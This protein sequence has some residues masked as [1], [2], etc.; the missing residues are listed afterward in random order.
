M[1]TGTL[2]ALCWSLTILLLFPTVEISSFAPTTTTRTTTTTTTTPNHPR[3]EFSWRLYGKRQK[4]RFNSKQPCKNRGS[5]VQERLLQAAQ[6]K[7]NGNDTD[8]HVVLMVDANNVRGTEGFQLTTYDLIR[9]LASWRRSMISI[10]SKGKENSSLEQQPHEPGMPISIL[11][12]ID[13]GGRP[14]AVSLDGIMLVFAGPNRTAD[15]VMVQDCQWLAAAVEQQQRQQFASGKQLKQ[16]R[17]DLFVVTNDRE[18]RSRCLKANRPSITNQDATSGSRTTKEASSKIKAKMNNNGNAVVVQV[19]DSLP[20]SGSLKTHWREEAMV[21]PLTSVTTATEPIHNTDQ[22]AELGNAMSK[23]ESDLRSYQRPPLLF[24][25]R[26]ERRRQGRQ[27]LP[28]TTTTTTT[29]DPP[30]NDDCET[31][32]LPRPLGA[33]E[34]PEKTWQR[35]L[36]AERLRRILLP[37]AKTVESSVVVEA[38]DST[39]TT[40]ATTATTEEH[41]FFWSS[42]QAMHNSFVGPPVNLCYDQR[43]R[44]D[45]NAQHSLSRYLADEDNSKSTAGS[46]ELT[47]TDPID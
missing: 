23:V 47:A 10:L 2:L 26:R 20:F 42:Y 46:N 11:C 37:S 36:V 13:H 5:S 4:A 15:D 35:V 24:L 9:V 38:A 33:D 29:A 6:V 21:T 27:L 3:C 17:L 7:V 44:H 45:K 16:Q 30:S 40:T 31:V 39:T 8:H 18:L 22:E 12:M 28:T 34:F 1:V 25:N 19:L 43:I 32:P 41:A 14:N